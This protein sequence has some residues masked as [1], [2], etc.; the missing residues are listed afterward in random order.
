MDYGRQIV[1]QAKLI[2]AS[3]LLARAA[4]RT[5]SNMPAIAIRKLKRLAWPA[6]NRFWTSRCDKKLA[7]VLDRIAAADLDDLRRLEFVE[8]LIQHIGLVKDK[9]Q[10]YGDDETYMNP[11]PRGLHQI[12]KQLAEFAIFLSQE[13]VGSFLEIGTYTGHTFTFLMAYLSRFNQNLIG[14]TLD[15]WDHNPVQQLW[16]GRFDARFVKERSQ[17]FATRV[18][19]FCFIDGDHSYDAVSADFANIGRNSKICA[20][21]DVNDAIVESWP[22]NAGGVPRFWEQLK[23]SADD[24]K[25]SEFTYHSRDNRVMGIGVAT[26]RDRVTGRPR[27]IR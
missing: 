13:R 19:D 21:H 12:P 23:G 2:A 24:W 4:S 18:F 22:G 8:G 14:I 15:I 27:P 7:L 5:R 26:H 1:P 11:I 20:F 16:K 17:D 6:Y 9:R 25:F 10:I 3:S